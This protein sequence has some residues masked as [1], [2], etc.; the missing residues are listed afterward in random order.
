MT[1]GFFGFLVMSLSDGQ[2]DE[3]RDTN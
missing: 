2:R 1:L 3:S